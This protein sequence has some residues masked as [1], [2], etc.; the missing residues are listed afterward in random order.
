MFF[1]VF[2]IFLGLIFYFVVF[3]VG[4]FV[5]LICIVEIGNDLMGE[6]CECVLVIEGV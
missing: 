6:F 1:F 4:I 3:E 5:K 2:L